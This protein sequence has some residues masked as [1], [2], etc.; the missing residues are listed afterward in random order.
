MKK[1]SFFLF[2]L[3]FCLGLFSCRSQ[4]ISCAQFIDLSNYKFNEDSLCKRLY[5]LKGIGLH[6]SFYIND[7]IP[8]MLERDD[9]LHLTPSD[10]DK[11]AM[12]FISS[13]NEEFAIMYSESLKTDDYLKSRYDFM[14]LISRFQKE[15]RNTE[16]IVNV[17]DSFSNLFGPK[18]F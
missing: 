13:S 11:K 14:H 6:L 2:L 8:T 15:A 3:F 16:V 5:M 4:R 12:V 1:N 17:I 7:K 10:V 18:A 9:L